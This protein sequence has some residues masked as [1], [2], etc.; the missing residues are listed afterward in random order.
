MSTCHDHSNIIGHS[1]IWNLLRCVLQMKNCGAPKVKNSPNCAS[2]FTTVILNVSRLVYVQYIQGVGVTYYFV[3]FKACTMLLCERVGSEYY[4]EMPG[5]SATRR[6]SSK[7][8]SFNVFFP[9]I[10][11]LWGRISHNFLKCI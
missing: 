6:K 2:R 4:N 5:C 11:V 1:I 8:I 3:H 9:I 7:W 10:S